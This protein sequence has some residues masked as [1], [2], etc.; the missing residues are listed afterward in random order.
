MYNKY[1][2]SFMEISPICK[3]H[4]NNKNIIVETEDYSEF[5]R[6]YITIKAILLGIKTKV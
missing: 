2:I 5:T 1:N 6:G 3:Y 4:Y